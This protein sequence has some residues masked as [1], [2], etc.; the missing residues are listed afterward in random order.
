M[1]DE[2]PAADAADRPGLRRTARME[3]FSDGVFAIAITLL[4]LDLAVPTTTESTRNLLDAIGHEWPGY[5]G[6]HR[7][8]RDGGR[9][10][11]RAQR[12]HRVPA[13]R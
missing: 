4:V 7:E 13:P 1:T 3:A 8:L 2:V 10:L 6:Y 5:L 11:A 9:S 12:G